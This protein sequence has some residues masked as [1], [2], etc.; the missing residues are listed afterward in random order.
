MILV[1]GLYLGNFIGNSSENPNSDYYKKYGKLNMV[2]GYIESEYVDEISPEN[3]IEKSLPKLLENLDPHS[4]YIPAKELLSV[5]EPLEGNFE[6][7]GIQF[8]IQQDTIMVVNTISGGPSEKEG[9]M[10]GDRI[11]KIDDSLV[12]G[13][14]ITN[15]MVLKKLKG[16]KGTKVNISVFRRHVDELLSFSITRDKIPINS[17]DVAYMIE[18]QIGYIKIGNFGSNTYKEFKKEV[19]KLK[20]SDMKSLIIDLRGNGGGYLDAATK[21]AD[22]FLED[23]KIIVYTEGKARPKTIAYAT[24]RGFCH[25]DN[26]IIL[27]DE[28]S[29]S[30]SEIL[31]GAIQDND[32]GKIVGRRS[33]GKGLVQEQSM[34]PDGS[35]IRLTIARYYTPTGRCIQKPYDNGI[36]NYLHEI[37]DRFENIDSNQQAS[38]VIKDTNKYIT[39]KGKVLYGGGGIMP[40]VLIPIDTLGWTNYL[41]QVTRRS[42]VYQFSFDYVDNNRDFLKK[43]EDY[44]DLNDFLDKAHVIN[45]FILFAEQKGV[46]KNY[47]EIKTSE[48]I[49]RTQLKAYIARNL[50]GDE[51]FYPTIKDVDIPLLKSVELLKQK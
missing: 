9:I 40:D 23:K 17:I 34:L 39:P 32:R 29:A 33:F 21:I 30:A 50:F 45:Q 3:L 4:V 38:E 37:A 51:G 12:A 46:K 10:P 44:K 7:I 20:K 31:A 2:L 22:E 28:W 25:D 5:S 24:K 36:D 1:T 41:S 8:N 42:L 11:V 49:L 26:V 15:N 16:P 13:T 18:E 14:K 47:P 35:A 6:G 27:I 43:F 48:S 19:L